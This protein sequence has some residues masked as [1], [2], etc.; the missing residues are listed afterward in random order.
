MGNVLQGED[1]RKDIARTW[2]NGSDKTGRGG[3]GCV[4]KWRVCHVAEGQAVF[5][6]AVTD[7]AGKG[8]QASL[9]GLAL[10]ILLKRTKEGF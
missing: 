1:G 9:R 3:Q 2:D 5:E 7:G 6:E 4:G 8:V 10:N